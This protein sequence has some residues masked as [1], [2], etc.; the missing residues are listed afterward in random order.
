MLK[1]LP[2]LEL[3]H[4]GPASFM[5]IASPSDPDGDAGLRPA[6][7]PIAAAGAARLRHV[8]DRMPGIT[9]RR[10]GRGFAYYDPAGVVIRDVST[11]RRVKALAVPPAWK[12]VWICP[13]PNGHIQA[14]GRDA[15]GRKQYRY[16]A[17]WRIVRDATKY[18]EML[19][20]GR[21]LPR[22]RRQVEADLARPGL[23]REKVLAAIMRLMERTLARIGNPEYA[24]E[25]H[26]FGL[27]T[28][29][30]R[31]VRV[32]GGRVE[33]DFRG[34]HGIR[35]HTVVS[36]RKLARI[37]ANCRDLPGSELFQYIDDAGV[38]HHM[39]SDDV[40][41][42][43]REISGCDITAKDFR[44]WAGTNLA[45][46][47]IAALGDAKPTKKALAGVVKEVAR[48]LGNTPAVCRSCYIHPRVLSGYLDG[49]LRPLLARLGDPAGEAGRWAV[50]RLV[51]RFLE[52]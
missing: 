39:D 49:S 24:R 8:S 35:H 15:R 19:A 40:N 23:P 20:F 28:L 30:N 6:I 26:S 27:T 33:L 22:I 46:L 10:A 52:G 43:L 5:D 45:V 12:E 32:A 34:K 29:Q 17:R 1:K 38:R 16:H 7:D 37:L 42:Y 51:M 36:D 13:D 9:R 11:L 41:A 50:E 25:N 31:H 47:A 2:P 48:Q 21:V 3:V 18:E 44:T 4:S 14:V